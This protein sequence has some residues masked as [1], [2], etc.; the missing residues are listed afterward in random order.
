MYA[1]PELMLSQKA[2]AAADAEGM[3]PDLYYCVEALK[4]T[5]CMLVPGSG[6]GQEPGT[7]H[8]RATLLSTVE[9]MEDVCKRLKVFNEKFHAT[10]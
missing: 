2:I 5:G 8:F 9:E 10:H 6:F 1:F 4:H 3:A 7:H